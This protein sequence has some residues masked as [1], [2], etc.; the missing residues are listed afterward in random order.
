[1]AF[2]STY[3]YFV[4]LVL[5]HWSYFVNQSNFMDS[6]FHASLHPNSH[7]QI[8]DAKLNLKIE[9]PQ[10]FERLVWDYRV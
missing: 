2:K 9:Y 1:M 7:H 5:L 4:K 6:G 10:L 8:V 3:I